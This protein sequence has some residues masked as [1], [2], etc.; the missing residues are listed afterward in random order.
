MPQGVRRPEKDCPELDSLN[1]GGG[2][3][4]KTSL[5]FEYDYQ[6]M[7]DEIIGQIKMM[8]EDRE[9]P[10]PN[11]FTEFGTFTVGESGATIYEVMHQRS[12]TIGNAGT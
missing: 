10:V 6:Y 5:A 1:I 7:A 4:I 9:I 12:R 11:I 2:F 3:P 8:C